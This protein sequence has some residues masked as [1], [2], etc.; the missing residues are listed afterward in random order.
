MATTTEKR[1][2]IID[3]KGSTQAIKDINALQKHAKSA[4]KNIARM[5]KTLGNLGFTIKAFIAY[6]LTAYI[7]GIGP[8]FIG[9]ADSVSLMRSRLD[10]VN[11]SSR[12]TVSVMGDLFEVAERSRGSIDSIA[13]LYTR[14]SVSAKELG[15]SQQQVLDFTE[16]VSDTFLLSGASAG[17]AASGVTQISQAMAKG[18]LDG[19]EFK[20]VMENNV[21][22]GELLS[23]T[24]G[25]T[26]GELLEMSKA[27]QITGDVLLSMGDSLGEVQEQ[28]ETMPTTFDQ[29]ATAWGNAFTRMISDSTT[30]NELLQR[31]NKSMAVSANLVSDA[32][33]D[34]P[35]KAAEEAIADQIDTVSELQEKLS[36]MTGPMEEMGFFFRALK[37]TN[38]DRFNIVLDQTFSKFRGAN[39][40]LKELR[41]ELDYLRTKD[42]FVGPPEPKAPSRGEAKDTPFS[43]WVE[44]LKKADAEL[45]LFFPKIEKLDELFFKDQVSETTYNS[46]LEKLTGSLSD[47]SGG[48]EEYK[49]ALAELNAIIDSGR[50]PREVLADDI[51]AINEQVAEM[52]NLAPAAAEAIKVMN[53]QFD[54]NQLKENKEEWIDWEDVAT[55]AVGGVTGALIDMAIDGKNSFADFAESFLINIAKMI[56]Q[57]AVL[58]AVSSP[59]GGLFGLFP[60]AN[61]NV[62]SGGNI[63]PFATGGVVTSPTFFPMANGTGLMGE[64]GPEAVL[65][66]DRDASGKLGV[67]ASGVGGGTV[68]NINNYSSASATAKTTTDSNGNKSIDIMIEEKVNA[69]IKGGGLD[70]QMRSVYGARRVGN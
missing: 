21:Y 18:K 27:G 33:S 4:D 53:E 2:I 16:L 24:L 67:K 44:G 68:V 42:D 61:G 31:F 60:S 56:A 46:E 20:S 49:T 7:A 29:M 23:K 57:A 43:K 36:K 58:K 40:D 62:F 59:T 66:L 65:P 30:M 11:D 48:T 6:R 1:V 37:N 63:V 3:V 39:E 47:A 19:D 32:F 10:L 52:K 17:E 25:V 9:V 22:F 45:N 15:A 55:T 34:S 13:T 69:A 28:V 54:A 35:I 14:L 38:L 12:S 41:A 8:A 5:G 50:T 51:A 64:A 70:R 26:R